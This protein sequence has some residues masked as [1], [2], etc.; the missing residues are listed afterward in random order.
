MINILASRHR[1][2]GLLFGLVSCLI[3]DACSTQAIAPQ[4]R[5]QQWAQP[6]PMTAL[7]NC[8]TV[9]DKLLRCAQP[10]VAGF[11][12]LQRLGI[13]HVLNLRNYHSDAKP[14]QGSGLTLHKLAMDAGDIST[15]QLRQAVALIDSLDGPVLVH[16]WH[17]SDRTGAV[18]AAYRI[19]KQG[20]SK[21]VAIDELLHGGYG[22]HSIYSNLVDTLERL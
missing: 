7:E 19:L 3:L 2:C 9:D 22:F 1:L 4:Y 17:G 13:K 14:A 15:T 18:V 5:P 10:T 8:F 16:C 12:Q 21:Q 20:W 11:Q 6:L